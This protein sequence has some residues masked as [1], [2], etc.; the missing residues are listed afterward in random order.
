[1]L[2]CYIVIMAG[3]K[4]HSVVYVKPS[5]AD[6]YAAQVGGMALE[7]EYD[8]DPPEVEVEVEE[9]E[10]GEGEGEGEGEE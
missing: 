4:P 9:S 5:F 8:Y 10:D 1:M 7:V 3:G 2:K 6:R